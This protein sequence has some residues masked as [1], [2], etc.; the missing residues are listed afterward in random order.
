M[1][2][3]KTFQSSKHRTTFAIYE[4]LRDYCHNFLY[5][6]F[7]MNM[8]D[9][10]KEARYDDSQNYTHV[11]LTM[12]GDTLSKIC[13]THSQIGCSPMKFAS[14]QYK[15]TTDNNCAITKNKISHLNTITPKIISEKEHFLQLPSET[16]AYAVLHINDDQV[17][18]VIC[19]DSSPPALFL[20]MLPPVIKNTIDM[21]LICIRKKH[22][23]FDIYGNLH[24]CENIGT[25]WKLLFG[26]KKQREMGMSR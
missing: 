9:R 18:V 19:I 20:S 24:N 13:K 3:T 7:T 5:D 2:R 25:Q 1:H 23:D 26:D 10:M 21:R 14:C 17:K 8:N 15:P 4:I 11:H 12:P 6:N 16:Y 22:H